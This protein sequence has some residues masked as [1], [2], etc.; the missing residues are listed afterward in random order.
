MQDPSQAL[1][2]AVD[3]HRK[4]NLAAA[5]ALYLQLLDARAGHFDALQMLGLLRYQQ[6]RFPD[7]LSLIGA[8]LQAKPDF[9]PA[10]LNYGLVLDALKRHRE[11][12][13]SYDRALA[14]QPDYA[15]ALYN[16]GV[17][18]RSLQR[19][20]EALASFERALSVRPQYLDAHVERGYALQDLGRPAEALA[21]YD[22]ALAIW[23]DH[24][25][26]LY[27]R[28][29]VLRDLRRPAEALASYDAALAI[30]PDY[31]EALN[32]RGLALLDLQRPADALASFERA[33]RF[34]PDYVRALNNRGNTLQDLGRPAEALAS[35]DE[36]L[37]IQP[38]Y[39]QA[40]YNRGVVLR[41]MHRPAEA[42]ASFER[43]LSI[44]PSHVDALNNRGV[45]L[46]DL[47]RPLEALAS[48][49]RALSIKPDHIEALNNRGNALRDLKRPVEAL[50]SFE[51]ALAVNPDDPDALNNRGLALLDLK[52]PA[53]AIASFEAALAI[54]PDHRYA[55]GGMAD[56]ALACC[57]WR[58]TTML[59]AE[60]A[61]HVERPHGLIVS[62]FTLL[63]HGGDPSLQLKCARR[64]VADKLPASP[65]PL[66]G[67]MTRRHDRL[68]TAYISADYN[69]HAMAFVMV[70][71]FELHDRARFETVGISL[72]R[73]DQSDIRARL[74]RSFDQF[75]DVQSKS[76]L[77]VANLLHD[78]QIDIAIDLNGHTQ[79][80]RLGVLA[81]RPAPIQVS[82]LGYSGSTGAD[83]I[84]YVIGD[85]TVLP[86]D[87]QPFFAERI[88]HLPNCF[89]AND[90]NRKI[91]AQ[92]P[93][94]RELELP[95]D[96]FVFCSFNNNYKI[97][98]P[99]FDVWMRLLH[100]VA[101]SVLW[102]L[103][104][105][106]DAE[107]SLRREAAERGID[108]ASLVFAGR[109]SHEEHLARH[110]AADLFL[111]TVPYNAHTTASDALWVGLPLLTCRGS[112][113]PGRVAASLLHAAGL[114]ELAADDLAEYEALA[115]RLATDAPLL[116][117][118][119]RRLEQNRA[120]CPLFDTDRFCRHIESAYATMWDLHERG[121]PPRSFSVEP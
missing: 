50:A 19:P 86:F 117:G 63:A 34:R 58:R 1:I 24:A 55:F 115:L 91:A 78:L 110:R 16:R 84:D 31:I 30:K 88:V 96:G 23:P 60:L 6:G 111:D 29:S 118:F 54:A 57:D 79:G 46:R 61:N 35:Y 65:R 73:D 11:A 106:G 116:Q 17:A 43:A 67:G 112:A 26:S 4:G 66:S 109:L 9:A 68:R 59:A 25:R 69:Q 8:A 100:A 14:L 90:S 41:D 113:F 94:R 13:A 49:D 119:R 75:H 76:D 89:M 21:S 80:G 33:L 47:N 39:A 20:A 27:N 15:E 28:G 70:R 62:P 5:E 95:D 32:N 105:N 101:G 22:K 82:Y 93:T 44:D 12:L 108:P 10:F 38:A 71:L 2:K 121:E 120:S 51:Q 45:V 48:Y 64:F 36:V 103:R 97:T 74:V 85:R 107:A 56:A 98:P 40:H 99:V 87:Q 42:F 53:Q 37:A 18:L 77:D 104:D 7:A 81:H 52:R 114:P 102:L 92:T 83:F 72:G 3:F